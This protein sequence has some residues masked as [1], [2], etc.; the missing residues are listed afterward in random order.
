M[1]LIQRR[2]RG[3]NA[4]K[5]AHLCCTPH[6]HLPP[7]ELK[8]SHLHCSNVPLL[9]PSQG[10][11]MAPL[12]PPCTTLSLLVTEKQK[13]EVLANV[14]NTFSPPNIISLFSVSKYSQ[15]FYLLRKV[16]PPS[17]LLPCKSGPP[18]LLNPLCEPQPMTR[19]HNKYLVFVS[20]SGS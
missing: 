8:P 1:S 9:S 3:W 18:S 6:F 16:K 17:G 20:S 14:L 2:M 19:K 12:S 5:P 15:G 10:L 4:E 11:S 13:P 7:Q